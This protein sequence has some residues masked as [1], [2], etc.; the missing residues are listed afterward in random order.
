MYLPHTSQQPGDHGQRDTSTTVIAHGQNAMHGPR[1]H[2]SR[3][4]RVPCIVITCSPQAT[5]PTSDECT[6]TSRFLL[7]RPPPKH[8]VTRPIT[9]ST[10]I[11]VQAI[12]MESGTDDIVVLTFSY[13]TASP[14]CVLHAC[15]TWPATRTHRTKVAYLPCLPAS[16][17]QSSNGISR[18]HA[19]P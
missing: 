10:V 17:I 19:R 5:L 8:P 11:V 14:A 15:K 2:K 13:N 12:S 7:C 9:G 1:L 6:P 3:N 18:S 16:P 4:T